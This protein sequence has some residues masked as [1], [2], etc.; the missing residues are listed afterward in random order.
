MSQKF[1][2]ADVDGTA[3]CGYA[4]NSPIEGWCFTI[5]PEHAT[6]FSSEE[7]A[8]K[9]IHDHYSKYQYKQHLAVIPQT[10]NPRQMPI[11]EG[12]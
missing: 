4:M 9:A 11:G 10:H 2:V 12:H 7:E 8:Q 6:T 1:V 3:V 5:M